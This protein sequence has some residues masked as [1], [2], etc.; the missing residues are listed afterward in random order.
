ML[1]NLSRD[2]A[3]KSSNAIKLFHAILLKFVSVKKAKK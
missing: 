1:F 3:T 2:A